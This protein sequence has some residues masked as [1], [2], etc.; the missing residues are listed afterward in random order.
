MATAA[1][2]EATRA[3]RAVVLGLVVAALGIRVVL[4]VRS[5]QPYGYV[6]DFY[7]PG[8]RHLYETGEIPQAKDC[9]LCWHPPASFVAGWP[10][11]AVGRWVSS[12]APNDD[13]ALRWLNLLP[14]LC[15]AIVLWYGWRLVTLFGIRGWDLPLAF[16]LM[17]AF[18]SLV[19][20]SYGFEADIVLAAV[21]AAFIYYACVWWRDPGRQPLLS[22]ARLGVLA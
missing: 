12:G 15:G 22:A 7:N 13:T 9:F 2:R 11:Y 19:I 18:P 10:F 16:G 8:V 20:S 17:A 3:Q 5:P 14:L 6:W 1:W 4:A 21:L